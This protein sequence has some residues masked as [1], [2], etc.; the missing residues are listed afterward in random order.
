VIVSQ[1]SPARRALAERLGAAVAVDP[2][3][4]DLAEVVDEVTGGRG[5][6][7]AIIAI[8]VPELVNQAVRLTRVAGRVN[9]FA[10]LAGKGWVE[11]EANLIHY[12]QVLLTGSASSRRKD[13]EVAIR[14]IESGRVETASMVTHR[15]GLGE[16]VD[17]LKVVGHGDALKVAV[18]PR[19]GR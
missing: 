9:L 15:F 11:V 14:L 7:L 5:V 10:G 3:S 4:Q 2:T 19:L 6:D 12:K 16:V 17:A 8:G 1:R 18:M 13:F